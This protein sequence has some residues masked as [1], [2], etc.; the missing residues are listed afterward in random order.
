M[1]IGDKA[2]RTALTVGA[3][4]PLEL[5]TAASITRAGKYYQLHKSP[6]GESHEGVLVV[7]YPHPDVPSGHVCM[8]T[9][10]MNQLAVTCHSQVL[11]S[12]LI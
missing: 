10:L 7:L 11:F 1:R 8:A 4:V 9:D 2:Y 5:A 3:F 12:P 6:S